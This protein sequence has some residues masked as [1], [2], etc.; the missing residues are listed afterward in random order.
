MNTLLFI[1]KPENHLKKLAVQ[2]WY[3]SYDYNVRKQ[4]LS[5]GNKYQA[6]KNGYF[7]VTPPKE[8]KGDSQFEITYNGDRLFLD[9]NLYSYYREEDED[10]EKFE[11]AKDFEEEKAKILLLH[12]QVDLSSRA[13]SIL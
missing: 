6:D 1:A 8:T 13:N 2:T 9:E 4:T 3:S 10:D 5:K 7:K 12:R 11:D